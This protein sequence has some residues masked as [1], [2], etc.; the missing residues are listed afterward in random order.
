M[1]ATDKVYERIGKLLRLSQSSNEHEAA[2]AAERAAVLMAEYGLEEADIKLR[3]NPQAV[4]DP[5]MEDN[6]ECGSRRDKWY[7]ILVDGIARSF[8]CRTYWQ[9]FRE[10]K[11]DKIVKHV[12]MVVV[13][14]P[15]EVGGVKYTAMLL[16]REMLVMVGRAYQA[17][18]EGNR[19]SWER[20]FLLGCALAIQARLV[21]RRNEILD[22]AMR[23]GASSQALVL[24]KRGD[25]EMASYMK[26]LHLRSS[27]P[28][29]MTRPDAFSH[30]KAAGREMHLG[31]G[32]KRLKAAPKL[33]R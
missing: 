3:D 14:R 17:V 10:C 32:G 27:G 12:R 5:I 19:T 7:G 2:L 25:D 16:E 26:R 6:I 22:E 24:V 23:H 29:R 11:P 30:G 4:L 13:G 1:E 8:G 28:T 33:V 15:R 18:G 9:T 21:S 20:N 31:V